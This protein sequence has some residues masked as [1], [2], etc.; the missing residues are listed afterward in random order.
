MDEEDNLENLT[1]IEID[2][3]DC[4]ALDENADFE[5]SSQ[6]MNLINPVCISPSSIS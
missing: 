6:E 2:F 3:A 5:R 1:G 4:F